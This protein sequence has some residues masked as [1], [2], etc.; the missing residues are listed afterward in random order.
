MQQG[1]GLCFGVFLCGF[2][3]KLGGWRWRK[4][5]C[6]QTSSKVRVVS[7]FLDIK[8]CCFCQREA[9]EGPQREGFIC[10]VE[11]LGDVHQGVSPSWGSRAHVRQARAFR[12]PL[13]KRHGILFPSQRQG[14]QSG[15]H[16]AAR[17]GA[18]PEGLFNLQ[19]FPLRSLKNVFLLT[20][21]QR[22]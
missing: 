12:T 4:D 16:P 14:V 8:V 2:A 21:I 19:N 15:Q 1:Q 3:S 11:S 5:C 7:V 10:V 9:G 18:G 6:A 17:K 13:K 20:H 22:Q